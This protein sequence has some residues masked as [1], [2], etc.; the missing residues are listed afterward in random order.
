M[1]RILLLFLLLFALKGFSQNRFPALK[2]R[3]DSLMSLHRYADALTCYEQAERI[4]AR[5][6]FMTSLFTRWQAA[7]LTY[8]LCAVM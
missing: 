8:T 7:R 4:G 6:I 1:K 2:A 5:K 3:G